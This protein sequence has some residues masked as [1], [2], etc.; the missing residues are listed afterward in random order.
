MIC[1]VN[2]ILKCESVLILL[3]C[4]LTQ[5]IT[6]NHKVSSFCLSLTLVVH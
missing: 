3:I 5:I 2:S 6:Y 1:E 4:E